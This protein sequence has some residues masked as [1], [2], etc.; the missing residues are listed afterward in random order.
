MKTIKIYFIAIIVF[1]FIFSPLSLFLNPKDNDI[2]I[3]G[4]FR[5]TTSEIQDD[6][7]I[8]VNANFAQSY[9]SQ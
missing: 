7:H 1:I 9:Y 4:G 6:N 8:V 2:M 3:I 5:S